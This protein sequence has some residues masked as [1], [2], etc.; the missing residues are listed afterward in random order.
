VPPKK[1]KKRG[2]KR[3]KKKK[4]KSLTGCENWPLKKTL[5]FF[6]PR[7]SVCFW[8]RILVIFLTE[9]MAEIWTQGAGGGG[10]EVRSFP[11]LWDYLFLPKRMCEEHVREYKLCAVFF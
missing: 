5:F 4:K 9:K 11:K 7:S 1:K 6:F 2:K 10:F 3:K 8:G